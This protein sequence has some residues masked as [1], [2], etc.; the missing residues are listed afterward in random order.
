M[1]YTPDGSVVIASD[2]TSYK[3]RISSLKKRT[4]YRVRVSSINDVGRGITRMSIALPALMIP[5][6]PIYVNVLLHKGSTRMALSTSLIIQFEPSFED[7]QW[8]DSFDIEFGH[9]SLEK[10]IEYINCESARNASLSCV[11]IESVSTTYSQNT[12]ENSSF[13]YE[14]ILY[15]LIPGKEYFFRVYSVIANRRGRSRLSDPLSIIPPVQTPNA[16]RDLYVTHINGSRLHV[17]WKIPDFDGGSRIDKYKIEYQQTYG[18]N[19]SSIYNCSC[20]FNYSNEKC[21]E[22]IY[23][24]TK[25]SYVDSSNTL[26]IEISNLIMGVFYNVNITACNNIGCGL[27]SSHKPVKTM[28]PPEIPTRV[29][30]A[31]H[32]YSTLSILYSPPVNNG[33]DEILSYYV[34]WAE[35]IDVYT[36]VRKNNTNGTNLTLANGTDLAVDNVTNAR[37]NTIV[38]QKYHF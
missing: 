12:N 17:S 14:R 1:D 31:V 10:V 26:A 21:G 19:C 11:S 3:Y 23:N 18:F 33:G 32:N 22:I 9:G 37:K 8:T 29:E 16:P 13:M 20:A 6:K 4:A 38:S 2:G 24:Y 30:Q 27:T 15:D 35:V 5:S 7:R 25:T 36:H 34:T 28:Q